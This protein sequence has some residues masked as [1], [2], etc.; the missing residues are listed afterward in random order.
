MDI[1][2]LHQLAADVEGMARKVANA[3]RAI[4]AEKDDARRA[5]E[6][7][8]RADMDRRCKASAAVFAAPERNEP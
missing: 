2:E 3:L 1:K 5:R 4:A 7:E 8:F 6:R